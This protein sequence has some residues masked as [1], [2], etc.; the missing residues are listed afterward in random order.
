MSAVPREISSGGSMATREISGI[1]GGTW[2]PREVSGLPAPREISGWSGTTW[3]PREISGFSGGSNVPREIS[4]ALPMPREISSALPLPREIS[5]LPAPREISG[6]PAREISAGS[7]TKSCS[8]AVVSTLSKWTLGTVEPRSSESKDRELASTD[9]EV[10]LMEWTA[11]HSGTVEGLR[12]NSDGQVLDWTISGGYSLRHS[13]DGAV[14]KKLATKP[15]QSS[16]TESRLHALDSNR[17]TSPPNDFAP[18]GPN[19]RPVGGEAVNKKVVS[20]A[21]IHLGDLTESVL[22]GIDG[23]SPTVELDPS[24]LNRIISSSGQHF[25]EWTALQ[26]SASENSK[27]VSSLS[28]WTMESAATPAAAGAAGLGSEWT[29]HSQDLLDARQNSLPSLR[30]QIAEASEWTAGANSLTVGGYSLTPDAEDGSTRVPME[31]QSALPPALTPA[32]ETP[33]PCKSLADMVEQDTKVDKETPALDTPCSIEGVE[34]SEGSERT[35]AAGEGGDLPGG[36]R[37]DLV[38]PHDFRA[39]HSSEAA[40]ASPRSF[41]GVS[42]RS[43]ASGSTVPVERQHNAGPLLLPATV[44]EASEEH[45]DGLITPPQITQPLRYSATN[46]LDSSYSSNSSNRSRGS[47]R[48][49][50]RGGSAKRGKKVKVLESPTRGLPAMAAA[51]GENSLRSNPLFAEGRGETEDD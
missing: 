17:P 35:V 12:R 24:T 25:S 41:M 4:S 38:S 8:T 3:V 18:W 36:V 9:K 39:L 27:V 46:S 33:S 7:E 10:E 23:Q 48:F 28:K 1:S 6:V 20:K 42:A 30:K 2:V 16:L 22:K 47:G 15:R 31:S 5:G 19:G 29:T 21:P 13:G 45:I 40:E 34:R 37:R 43:G 44:Q 51:A 26:R 49:R 14:N 50:L 11:A 32:E